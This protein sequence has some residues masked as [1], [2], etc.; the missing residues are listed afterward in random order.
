MECETCSELPSRAAAEG[1]Q[2]QGSVGVPGLP[3]GVSAAAPWHCC[4]ESAP[5]VTLMYSEVLVLIQVHPSLLCI[6]LASLAHWSSSV[7]PLQ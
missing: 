5:A 7:V 2:S 6:C 4:S 3:A 1:W